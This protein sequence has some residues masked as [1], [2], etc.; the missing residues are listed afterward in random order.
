MFRY[1][2]ASGMFSADLA[3]FQAAGSTESTSPDYITAPYALEDRVPAPTPGDNV[4]AA[5]QQR[6]E[7]ALA[8]AERLA[9]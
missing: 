8:L 4:E 1:D 9:V 3:Q 5:A 7:K 6:L 2:P